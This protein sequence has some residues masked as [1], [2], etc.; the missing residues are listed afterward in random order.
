[1]SEIAELEEKI[2]SWAADIT[3]RAQRLVTEA[4]PVVHDGADALQKLTSS[5]IVSELQQYGEDILPPE[6]VDAIVSLIRGAGEAAARIASLTTPP[7]P[8]ADP[9]PQ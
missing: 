8:A 2:R 3:D 4:A 9:A 7:A 6:T 1:M 5:K